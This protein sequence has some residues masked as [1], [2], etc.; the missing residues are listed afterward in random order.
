M[1]T[2][3]KKAIKLVLA[4]IALIIV[5]VATGSLNITFEDLWGKAM[6]FLPKLYES[7]SGYLDVLPYTSATFLIG[8]GLAFW[9]A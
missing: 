8:L 2:I 7:G 9:K 4:V 3:I 1:G 5:L 6:E